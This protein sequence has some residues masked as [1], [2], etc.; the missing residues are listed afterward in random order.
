MATESPHDEITGRH[1]HLRRLT[2]RV[3]FVATEIGCGGLADNE[4]VAT[5]FNMTT[6]DTMD[7]GAPFTAIELRMQLGT[8]ET[9]VSDAYKRWDALSMEAV[10]DDAIEFDDAAHFAARHAAMADY[11]RLRSWYRATLDA[12]HATSTDD[13]MEIRTGW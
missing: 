5:L 11:E 2:H 8:L 1:A 12:Y 4:F 13:S 6:T 3:G 10:F 7:N 9:M